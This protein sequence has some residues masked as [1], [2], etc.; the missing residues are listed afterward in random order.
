MARSPVYERWLLEKVK[1][2]DTSIVKGFTGWR[3]GDDG[4]EE[5]EITKM[6]F[7]FLVILNLLLKKKY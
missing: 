6:I 2:T 1:A 4:G 7:F 3:R 5:N